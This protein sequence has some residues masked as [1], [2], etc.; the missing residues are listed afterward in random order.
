MN[1][2]QHS[3]SHALLTW[4]DENKRHLP[5]RDAATPYHVWIS[6]VMLQQTQVETVIPFYHR[7][8]EEV[9]SLYHLANLETSQLL[10]LWQGLGYYRRAIKL[11]EAAQIIVKQFEGNMPSDVEVLMSL[12]G[13]GG[14]TARAIA[15]I[16]FGKPYIALDGNIKRIASRLFLIEEANTSAIFKKIATDAFQEIISHR[17]PGDFNQALMDLANRFC[18]KN[19]SP[20]CSK[21]PIKSFC[22][23]NHEGTVDQYPK[24]IMKAKRR[25]ESKTVLLI[26]YKGFLAINKRP[27]KGLLAQLYEPITLEGNKD[28]KDILTFLSKEK[29][30]ITSIK[31]LETLRYHFSHLSWRLKCVKIEVTSSNKQ[32]IW[33]NWDDLNNT[34]PLLTAALKCIRHIL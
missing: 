7:F 16:A 6:E 11:L 30:T 18:L 14:Y 24:V 1:E 34:Y 17:R 33:A 8:L 22:K 21:C 10:K 9:P 28:D 26:V 27:S 25:E 29:L 23:A 12:P 2:E 19:R 32:W 5:W 31:N 13:I 15:S 3:L 4:Y 20:L